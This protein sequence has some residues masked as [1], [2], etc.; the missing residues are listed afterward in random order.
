MGGSG[1]GLAHIRRAFHTYADAHK[2]DRSQTEF[3]SATHYLILY[4][5]IA[6]RAG[7]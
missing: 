5:N 2:G 7:P 1:D 6:M 4:T 3:A